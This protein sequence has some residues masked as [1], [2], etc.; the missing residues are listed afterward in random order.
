[1]FPHL[2]PASISVLPT[3]ATCLIHLIFLHLTI[4]TIYCVYWAWSFSL[5]YFL[6]LPATSF[7]LVLNMLYS[8]TILVYVLLSL[9]EIKFH[10]H[11]IQQSKGKIWISMQISNKTFPA[12]VCGKIPKLW[13]N[14]CLGF[15]KQ[16]SEFYACKFL[17][18]Y[19]TQSHLTF[20][21]LFCWLLYSY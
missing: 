7:I 19:G 13:Q 4:L 12:C 3:Q 17:Y 18:S 21:I 8:W 2:N 16:V 10:T 5:S 11:T 14:K 6:Q 1:M 15:F 9:W 20:N